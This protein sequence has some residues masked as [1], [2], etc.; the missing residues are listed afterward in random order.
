[1]KVGKF[2]AIVVLFLFACVSKQS[3]QDAK[4]AIKY[5]DVD[6]DQMPDSTCFV[7]AVS[8]NEC[9]GKLPVFWL[10]TQVKV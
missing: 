7:E 5:K 10:I 1:M 8:D 2:A 9:A 4:H 3:I 6:F